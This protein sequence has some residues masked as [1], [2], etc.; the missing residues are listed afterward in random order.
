MEKASD[1]VWHKG[2]S[3]KLYNLG[4]DI[5]L[6]KWI[7]SFLLDRELIMNINDTLQ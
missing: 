7:K 3:T 2:L 6:I 4:S 1:Q 5:S